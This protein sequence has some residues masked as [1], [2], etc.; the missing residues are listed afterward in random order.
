M[1][2]YVFSVA[3]ISNLLVSPEITASRDEVFGARTALSACSSVVS[4]DWRTRLSALLW[5]RLCR[6]ALYRRFVIGRAPEISR[7]LA[8]ADAPQNK[9]L[10][11][12]RLQICAT[13]LRR[14]VNPHISA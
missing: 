7:A 5:L 1:N 10:R 14:A 8:L 13:R 3:Q 9:I 11:Y 12:G 2:M 6:A 4:S